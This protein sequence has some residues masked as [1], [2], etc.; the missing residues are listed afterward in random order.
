MPRVDEVADGANTRRL[1]YE[2]VLDVTH[3]RGGTQIEVKVT[4]EPSSSTSGRR[5][6]A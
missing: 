3:R 4:S 5:V 1:A 6:V 2:G